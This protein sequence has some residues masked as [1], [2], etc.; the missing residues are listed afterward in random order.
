ME[1]VTAPNTSYFAQATG[2]TTPS[3]RRAPRKG[4]ELAAFKAQLEADRAARQAD[5]DARGLKRP[6]PKP[7]AEAAPAVASAPERVTVRSVVGEFGKPG[8]KDTTKEF[9]RILKVAGIRLAVQVPGHHGITLS[10]WQGRP[11]TQQPIAKGFT[12]ASFH[13]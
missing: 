5:R 13:V 10:W 12:H 2:Y 11:P 1:N 6:G 4:A 7:A 3:G 9:L 8:A